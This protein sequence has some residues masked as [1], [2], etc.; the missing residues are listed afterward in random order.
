MV[1][2]GGAEAGVLALDLDDARLEVDAARG[3]RVTALVF[4]GR[5]LLTGD[6]VDPVNFGSTFWTSPQS[7]W[8]W[9]PIFEIDAAPYEASREHDALV[10]RGPVSETLGVSV[11]KRFSVDYARRA[12]VM[13]FSVTNEATLAARLAPWQVTRVRPGGLTFFAAGSGALPHSDLPVRDAGGVTWLH[14]DAATIAGH[15]KLFADTSEGWLAHLDGDALLVKTFDV[16]ARDAH[17]PGEAQVE[18]YAASAHRYLEL[19]AQGACETIA[20]GSTLSWRVEWRLRRVPAEAPR[21]VGAAE[22]V[23]LARQIAAGLA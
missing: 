11:E 14:H 20:P 5:N 12:F 4:D 17:A 3:G 19:E 10:L 8:G 15:Q 13:T 16:V 23:A 22:L 2:P 7:Q 6:D 18:L 9:P 1:E 21:V